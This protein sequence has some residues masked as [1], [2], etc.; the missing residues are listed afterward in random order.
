MLQDK[1]KRKWSIAGCD[2]ESKAKINKWK[3]SSKKAEFRNPCIA[4]F[5]FLWGK[6]VQNVFKTAGFAE[7]GNKT[8]KLYEVK[9]SGFQHNNFIFFKLLPMPQNQ[10]I[11]DVL[12]FAL[13]RNEITNHN[14]APDYRIYRLLQGS[15]LSDQFVADGFTS[16]WV[17]HSISMQMKLL[18]S[19]F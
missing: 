9:H 17:P 8:L 7:I 6:T 12:H 15:Q 16:L 10:K 4:A 5:E 19:F 1:T 18:H 11:S 14:I 13:I 3:N 2:F